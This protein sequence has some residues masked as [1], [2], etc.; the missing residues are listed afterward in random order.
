MAV[1]ESV[2]LPLNWF[3]MGLSHAERI[4]SK[5]AISEHEVVDLTVSPLCSNL[6]V[7]SL[8]LATSASFLFRLHNFGRVFFSTIFIFSQTQEINI[9]DTL[10]D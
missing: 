1:E 6:L 4:S 7:V 2:S 3:Q 10:D 9:D 8:S 5:Y